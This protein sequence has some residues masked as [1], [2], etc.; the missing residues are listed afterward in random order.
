[1]QVQGH[2]LF[3]MGISFDTWSFDYVNPWLVFIRIIYIYQPLK[4][5]GENPLLCSVGNLLAE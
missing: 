2:G 3:H 5:C 1:M 4:R